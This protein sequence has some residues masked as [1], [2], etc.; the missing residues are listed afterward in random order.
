MFKIMHKINQVLRLN[1][2]LLLILFTFN[3]G[4]SDEQLF[5]KMQS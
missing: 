5:K 1:L 2:V 3:R 4:N